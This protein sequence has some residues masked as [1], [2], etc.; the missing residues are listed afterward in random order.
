MNTKKF[1]I[2]LVLRILET[3]S[4]KDNP[5]TQVEIA[6]L[7]SSKFP[8]DRKTVGRNIKFL[9]EMKYPIVKTSRGFY[10]DKQLF[11]RK[12]VEYVINSV[13]ENKAPCADKAELCKKLRSSLSSHYKSQF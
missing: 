6:N 3:Q 12:E 8:C 4:D 10:M 9:I 11:D 1:L 7:I 2:V 5:I 13:I